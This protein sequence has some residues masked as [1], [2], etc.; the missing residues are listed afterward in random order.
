MRAESVHAAL[1]IVVIVGLGLAVFAA[2]ESIFPAAEGFCSVNS[3][4]SCAKVDSSG[5]TTTLGI[6][7]WAIGIAGFV[8]LLVIDIPLYRTWRPDLLKAL[9]GLSAL[10]VVVSAYFAYVELAIIQALC[11]VCFSTYLAN[12]AVLVLSLYLLRTSSSD[13]HDADA[14]ESASDSEP[15]AST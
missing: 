15:R 10:G 9:V 6:Q 12:G 3:Y 1:L 2:V 8:L 7:D 4:V 11:L 13:E 14:N 5:H